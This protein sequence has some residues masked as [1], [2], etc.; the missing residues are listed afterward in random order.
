M[1]ALLLFVPG[2]VPAWGGAGAALILA[3][4]GPFIPWGPSAAERVLWAAVVAAGFVSVVRGRAAFWLAAVLAGSPA[5][6]RLWVL[7]G[8]AYRDA[9]EFRGFSWAAFAAGIAVLF[10]AALPIRS[11]VT[12]AYQRHFRH[13]TPEELARQSLFHRQ[14]VS[15]LMAIAGLYWVLSP[16]WTTPK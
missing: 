8:R 3:I 1:I 2:P 11:L 13:L 7:E 16:L 6:A 12:A 15:R 4:V 14:V 10:V 9:T 5:A